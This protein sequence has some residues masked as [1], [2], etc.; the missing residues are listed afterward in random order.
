MPRNYDTYANYVKLGQKHLD[1]LI[2]LV[3]NYHHYCYYHYYYMMEESA[4]NGRTD[5]R[6]KS[7][8]IEESVMDGRTVTFS[9]RQR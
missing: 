7:I 8:M 6:N 1:E 2:V 9:R 3:R 5:V 4:M